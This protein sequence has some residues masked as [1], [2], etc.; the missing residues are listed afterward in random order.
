MRWLRDAV[1]NIARYQC[2]LK[3]FDYN[4][5]IHAKIYVDVKLQYNQIRRAHKNS[6]IF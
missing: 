1:E 3:I 5:K 4:S 2:K 6:K